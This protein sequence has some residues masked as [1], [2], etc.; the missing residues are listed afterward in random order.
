MLLPHPR[1]HAAHLYPLHACRLQLP[2]QHVHTMMRGSCSFLW[3]SKHVSPF[4]R[5][6][7]RTLLIYFCFHALFEDHLRR[8]LFQQVLVY[9]WPSMFTLREINQMERA[10]CSPIWSASSTSI[11]QCCAISNI[12]FHIRFRAPQLGAPLLYSS[13]TVSTTA[14]LLQPETTT[15]LTGGEWRLPLAYSRRMSSHLSPSQLELWPSVASSPVSQPAMCKPP[16]HTSAAHVQH[17]KQVVF[18]CGF[19][20][21]TFLSFFSPELVCSAPHP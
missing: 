14:P 11:P 1:C 10:V 20:Q 7:L 5:C 6:Y 4:F 13:Y 19:R 21:V 8:Y 18:L 12:T 16:A 15:A 17:D 9:C 3:G 2:L